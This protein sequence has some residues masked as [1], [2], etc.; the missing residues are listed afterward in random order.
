M[1]LVALLNESIPHIIAS[2]VTHLLAT[3]W[4]AFQIFNTKGFEDDF[5]KVITHGACNGV[6]NLLGDFWKIR[7][8]AEYASLALNVVALFVSGILSWKLFKVS[9]SSTFANVELTGILVFWMANFQ[10]GWCIIDY[11]P[12]L[13]VGA[14]ALHLFAI[15]L[16]L[17]GCYCCFVAR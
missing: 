15:V 13:Q 8:D 16:F 2:L 17:H 10:T 6:P 12:Y 9:V 7:Q 3:G 4:A 11:Q 1:S 5:A 14:C